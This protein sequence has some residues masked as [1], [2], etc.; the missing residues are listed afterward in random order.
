MYPTAARGQHYDVIAGD[1]YQLDP[2][3]DLHDGRVELRGE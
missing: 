1:S 3:R 2:A